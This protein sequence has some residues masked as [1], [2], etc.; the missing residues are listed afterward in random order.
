MGVELGAGQKGE[1]PTVL[2]R[3]RLKANCAE[4]QSAHK[5]NTNT[6]KFI[7]FP[8]VLAVFPVRMPSKWMR[9]RA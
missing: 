1:K 2:T 3:N 4:K 5:C 8:V 7:A 6:N 9:G